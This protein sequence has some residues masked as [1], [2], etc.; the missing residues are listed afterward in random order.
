M[1][2]QCLMALLLG[3]GLC[4]APAGYSQE[5]PQGDTAAGVRGVESRTSRTQ[6]LFRPEARTPETAAGQRSDQKI[7]PWH[8]DTIHDF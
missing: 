2:R 7:A 4:M 6:D 5:H 1:I 3:I 8:D